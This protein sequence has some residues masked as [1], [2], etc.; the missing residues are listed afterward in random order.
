MSRRPGY[1][2][3]NRISEQ[4]SA[5]TIRMLESFAYRA[6]SFSAH[7]VLSRVEI[8]HGHHGGNDNGKLPV[9]Y[10]DFAKY[11]VH[12]HGVSAAIRECVAL[13]FLEIT[14]Q[15]HAGNADFRSPNKY[16]I[17]YL[18]AG[19]AKPTNEWQ[20]IETDEKAAA[21]AQKAR[22]KTEFHPLKTPRF[23]P[24]N[25]GRKPKF[26]PPKIGATAIPRNQGVLSISGCGSTAPTPT[27]ALVIDLPPLAISGG[28]RPAR[29]S[30]DG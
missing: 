23:N 18:Y 13:G 7:R 29:A 17:T 12:R 6:L 15:G 4:F 9:T 28:R 5:R 21:I 26:P 22:Q 1:R 8:E 20:R 25:R 16:R 2:Q 14:E 10:E 24:G 27:P 30:K 11:G 3:R 19:G